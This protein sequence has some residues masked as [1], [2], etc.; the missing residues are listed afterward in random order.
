MKCKKILNNKKQCRAFAQKGKD[1][2]FRHDPTLKEI[3]LSASSKGGQNRVLQG[4]YGNEVILNSPSDIKNFI[5]IVIN[6]VW[7]GLVP[8][9]VG[10]S[11]GFLAKCWLEAHN[12]AEIQDRLEALEEK[13]ERGM[14]K[15]S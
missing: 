1:F 9:P 3:G 11:M 5:A 13:V 15:S 12:S 14:S 10:S 6:G 2:C 4:I 8:V 7:T